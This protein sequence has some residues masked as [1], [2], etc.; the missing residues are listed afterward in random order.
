[1]NEVKSYTVD[2]IEEMYGISRQRLI[3]NI[4]EGKL[5]GTQMPGK[6]YRVDVKEIERFI[7]ELND[8]SNNK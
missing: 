1:M 3:K 6:A 7:K 2:E 5:K 4:K 8:K